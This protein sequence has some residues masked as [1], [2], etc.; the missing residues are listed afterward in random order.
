MAL[1]GKFAHLTKDFTQLKL[2]QG[3]LELFLHKHLILHLFGA[4]I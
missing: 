4:G 1:K 3:T 2:R